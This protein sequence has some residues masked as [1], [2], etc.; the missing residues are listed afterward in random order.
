MHIVMDS[1]R[2]CRITGLPESHSAPR[3]KFKVVVNVSFLDSY[4]VVATV[5][6]VISAV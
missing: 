6:V 3:D 4:L 2:A 1:A 5:L